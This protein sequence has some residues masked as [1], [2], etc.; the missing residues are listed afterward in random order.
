MRTLH[1]DGSNKSLQP[2]DGRRDDLLPMTSTLKSETQ[3]VSLDVRLFSGEG[4][5]ILRRCILSVTGPGSLF[6]LL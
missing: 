1:D 2:T 3:L 6:V 5:V 4:L